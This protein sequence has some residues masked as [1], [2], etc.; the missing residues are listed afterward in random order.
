MRDCKKEALVYR[1]ISLL[2]VLSRR[3]KTFYL[4]LVTRYFL[5]ATRYFLLVTRYFLLVDV[6]LI[7]FRLDFQIMANE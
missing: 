6:D 7:A 3:G 5:L 2:P 1:P 4:L